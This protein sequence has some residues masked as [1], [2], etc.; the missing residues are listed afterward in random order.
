MFIG[1]ATGDGDVEDF[2]LEVAALA[3][4]TDLAKTE[5]EHAICAYMRLAQLPALR[6]L[7][8][9][10]CL[11]N[12][13][14]LSIIDHILCTLHPETPKETWQAID[15]FLVGMFTPRKA[16]Q[17]FPSSRSVAL[18]LRKLVGKIDETINFDPKRRKERAEQARETSIS[19]VPGYTNDVKNAAIIISG[20]TSTIAGYEA[21]LRAVAREGH[22]TLAEALDAV[23]HGGAQPAS[24]PVTY[25]FTPKGRD[26]AYYPGHGWDANGEVPEPTV[27]LDDIA[28]EVVEGYAPTEHM[29]NYV[30]ARDGVCIFPG[31]DRAAEECQLDHRVPYD[32]GGP[33]TPGN[34]FCLCAHHHNVKTDRRA[35]YIPDPSSGEIVW[36]FEDGTWATTEP[37]GILV[38][39]T[40]PTVPRW[41]ASAADIQRRRGS[42][43]RFYARCHALLDEHDNGASLR[44]TLQ[45]IQTLEQE[46]GMTFPFKPDAKAPVDSPQ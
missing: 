8:E 3:Q 9:R 14:R 22:L 41:K 11:I 25:A 42:A 34:L 4:E 2:D 23:F 32:A 17:P 28:A 7:Q 13:K 10:T 35:F 12:I 16:D 1:Y 15:S 38:E 31:C 40:T 45:Q 6:E 30:R 46:Y 29:R 37:E 26:T 44:H 5:I 33:T 21:T 18:R 36:L 27:D 20:A 43:A 24:R 19:F 39:E